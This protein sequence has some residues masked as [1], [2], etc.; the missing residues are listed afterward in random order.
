M[1]LRVNRR[2][3]TMPTSNEPTIN[4]HVNMRAA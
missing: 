1:M 3:I 4:I 2:V